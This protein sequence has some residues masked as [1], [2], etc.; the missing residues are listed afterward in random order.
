MPI[1]QYVEDSKVQELALSQEYD[2]RTSA[3]TVV[4][5]AHFGRV[6]YGRWATRDQCVGIHIFN[7]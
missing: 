7:G 6:F 2:V 4:L 5:P 3:E 1:Y